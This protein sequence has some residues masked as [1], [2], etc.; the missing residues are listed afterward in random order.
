[1][2]PSHTPEKLLQEELLKKHQAAQFIQASVR[3]IDSYMK[4]GLP[5]SKLP[6]GKVLFRK[7]QLLAWIEK[8][9]HGSV[10]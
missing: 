5:F 3:T 2:E 6:S 1:M 4:Q 10:I 7:S 8:Y 9:Q